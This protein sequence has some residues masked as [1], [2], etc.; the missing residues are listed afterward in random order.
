MAGRRLFPFLRWWNFVGWDT[1]RADCFAGLTGAVIVLPQG[2]A[3]AMIAGLPPE[4]GLYTAIV[5]PIVAGLFGSSL[6]LISGPTTAISIVVFSTI[7]PL[8]PPG[9]PEYI[10]IALTLTFLAGAWQFTLGLARMGILVN[11]VSHSVV[12]GFTAGASILI[13]TSQLKHVFGLQ[14]P[15]GASFLQ[16]WMRVVQDIESMNHYVL[17]IALLTLGCAIFFKTYRSRWPGLLIAMLVGSLASL[18]LDGH[19]HGVPLMGKLPAQL[20][21]PSLPDFSITTLREL[22]PKAL[23]VALLGL[24][25]ALSIARSISTRSG[26]QINGN[27]EFIGQGLSNMVGS[28]FSSYAGSGSF[29]RS[30]I[31]Y[32]AGA[33][34]PLAGVFS[35]VFLALIVL[36]VAP[37][38][39]YLPIPA[40]GGV[41][42]LVAYNLIDFHH[43]RSIIRTSREETTVLLTTF[44]STLLLDLEFAIYAGVLLS[45]ILYLTRVA[46]P[47][48]VNLTPNPDPAGQIFIDTDKEC[49]Q[50]KIIRIDG[51]LF[52]GAVQHIEES[53]QNMDRDSIF[54]RHVLIVGCGINSI[55][56]SGAELLMQEARRRRKLGGDLYLSGLKQQVKD[57]LERGGYL[58]EL[59]EDHVF[60]SERDAL[61]GIVRRLDLT[62][63]S[64]CETLLFEVCKKVES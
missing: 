58:K 57:L 60:A 16:T 19:R 29:T 61:A 18:L 48:I 17:G 53:L 42:L 22:A 38:T 14:V 46:H 51:S 8:A 50:F 62:R 20:P 11:F 37:L 52:F 47:Q 41:I 10:R 6:H 36:L 35:A 2:V 40:M 32:Q 24:I 21:P 9:T 45:L 4:Y 31:N 26:Q 49:S 44:L 59:G 56:V 63:C 3:F 27:Q 43:I 25:E 23:A 34:T 39:A 54:K 55:D 33:M 30:G 28:F 1:L 13:A 7:S 12:V 64:H 5:T 15:R